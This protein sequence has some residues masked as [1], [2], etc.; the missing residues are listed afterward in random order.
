MGQGHDPFNMPYRQSPSPNHHESYATPSYPLHNISP[1]PPPPFLQPQQQQ[2]YLTYTPDQSYSAADLNHPPPPL[3]NQT[4]TTLFQPYEDPDQDEDMGDLP[5][6]RAPSGRSQESF[7][8]I[9]GRYDS[10]PP[11]DD[12]NNNIRYGR[13][14]QRVQRR[15]KTLKRVECVSY[16]FISFAH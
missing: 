8:N 16:L 14:P 6:L 2:P 9:P 3:S 13:I 11:D 10:I 5:L 15:Y 7:V 12:A 1:P 4:S